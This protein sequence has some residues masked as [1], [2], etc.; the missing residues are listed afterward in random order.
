MLNNENKSKRNK[1]ISDQDFFDEIL[2]IEPN[3]C[4]RVDLSSLSL[5]ASEDDV[6]NHLIDYFPKKIYAKG[7]LCDTNIFKDVFS[8]FLFHSTNIFFEIFLKSDPIFDIL[9]QNE[10]KKSF[11]TKKV[12]Y[13]RRIHGGLK[14][15]EYILPIILKNYYLFKEKDLFELNKDV[16]KKAFETGRFYINS[17]GLLVNLWDFV[18]ESKDDLL[19]LPKKIFNINESSFLDMKKFESNIEDFKVKQEIISDLEEVEKNNFEERILNKKCTE[20]LLKKIEY[21]KNYKGKK[22]TV[23]KKDNMAFYLKDFFDKNIMETDFKKKSVLEKNFHLY[24]GV[25]LIEAKKEMID[26]LEFLKSRFPNFKE[27]I[28][29]VIGSLCISLL[30]E[31]GEVHFEPI[32]MLGSSGIGKT[33]FASELAKVLEVK[34]EIWPVSNLNQGFSMSGLDFGWASG[35]TGNIFNLL[36]YKNIA[37]PI[38]LLDELDKGMDSPSVNSNSVYPIMLQLFEKET[39]KRFLDNALEMELDASYFNWICTANDIS[40]IPNVLLTRLKVF[41]IKKPNEKEMIPVIK[42]I[43]TKLR[44]EELNGDM[45]SITIPENF[46]S[47]LLEFEPR[48]VRKILQDTMRYSAEMFVKS[49]QESIGSIVLNDF[50]LQKA[51]KLEPN[52]QN[53]NR[54]K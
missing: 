6:L 41:N 26:N 3:Q 12:T 24:Y 7:K 19:K 13:V 36:A 39:S 32:L 34:S 18:E 51:L 25:P 5:D 53:K 16:I 2:S 20:D 44:K 29:Y 30:K 45:F 27:V 1:E 46:Y 28:D 15:L 21:N 42:S 49:N 37:N 54:M 43:Y 33:A 8:S 4:E 35:K 38:I 40:E 14:E 50:A 52:Q 48:K 10:E 23:I 31:G 9:I 17:E 47:C 11:F 22:A